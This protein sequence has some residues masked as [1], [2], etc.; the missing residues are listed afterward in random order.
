MGIWDYP[1]VRSSFVA[2]WCARTRIR[3]TF[4]KDLQHDEPTVASFWRTNLDGSMVMWITRLPVRF[5]FAMQNRQTSPR[6][7]SLQYGRRG[8]SPLHYHLV[9]VVH[10][11]RTVSH[12]SLL[13]PVVIKIVKM[14]HGGV[15][16]RPKTSPV[17][18]CGQLTSKPLRSLRTQ[19]P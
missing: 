9:P 6:K 8:D 14:G 11:Q 10:K 2:V 13:S 16:M 17:L 3:W 18:W 12:S 7:M 15:F 19:H 4:V 1:S 5:F